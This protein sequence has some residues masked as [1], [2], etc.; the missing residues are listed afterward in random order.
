[1]HK[2]NTKRSTQLRNMILSFS[3]YVGFVLLLTIAAYALEP[4]QEDWFYL[5][6]GNDGTDTGVGCVDDC[7]D[8]FDPFEVH[9]GDS[10]FF[11]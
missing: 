8:E 11:I 6:H 2:P 9:A 5:E 7:L 4:V 3:A 10:V 1:M